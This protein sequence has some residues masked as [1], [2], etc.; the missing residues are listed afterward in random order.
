[1]KCHRL[2]RRDPIT[3]ETIETARGEDALTSGFQ[4]GV[5]CAQ[6]RLERAVRRAVASMKLS[7]GTPHAHDLGMN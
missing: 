3:S 5:Q 6:A 4:S 1:M 2:A 7:S